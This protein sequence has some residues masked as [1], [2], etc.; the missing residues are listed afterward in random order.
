MNNQNDP[1]WFVD[2]VHADTSETIG[3]LPYQEAVIYHNFFLPLDGVVEVRVRRCLR[4]PYKRPSVHLDDRPSVQ[5]AH[6][7][8]TQLEIMD[9]QG[10]SRPHSS[11][12]SAE[13]APASS[14]ASAS[15]VPSYLPH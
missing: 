3:P 13:S 12:R 6:P 4:A 9:L 2:I 5:L 10:P 11:R 8:Q 15:R 7:R 1:T 14:P